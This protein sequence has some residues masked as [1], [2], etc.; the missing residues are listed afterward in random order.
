MTAF[1]YLKQL[2]DVCQFQTREKSKTGMASNGELKR[3]IKNNALVLNGFRVVDF[4][5]EIDYPL[6]SVILFPNN[7]ITIL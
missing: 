3:W 4:N 2:H 6:F 7:R 1:E 5:E